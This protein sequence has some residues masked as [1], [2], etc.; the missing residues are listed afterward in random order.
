M[1]IID[2]RSKCSGCKACANAC[3]VQAITFTYDDE[4][5]WYPEVD[6]DK[7]VNCG[8][9]EKVCP[10][11]DD[12]HGVPEDN[13]CFETQFF[14]ARL[15][16]DSLLDGV[17][18]GGAFYGLA[19]AVLT[20]GGV[21]YGAAREDVDHVFHTRIS[22]A[23]D[24][25]K[26][27]KSKYLQSDMGTCYKTAREDLSAGRKVLFSGTGCQIAA[28]NRFLGKQHDN[29][30][31]CEV[32]CHGVPLQSVW[33]L[34]R[35]DKESR[36]GKKIVDIDFRDKSKGWSNNQYKTVYEDGSEE[37]ELSVSHPFHAGYLKGLFYRPSCGTCPFASM[38]R[39]AD[40]T[41]ADYW[42]Y[43]GR[44]KEGNLGVSL[45]GVNSLKGLNIMKSLEKWLIMEDSSGQD[46]LLSCRHMDDHP[47][48]NPLR[49]AFLKRLFKKGYYAAAK[50][51]IIDVSIINRIKN[52]IRRMVR[53]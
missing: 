11:R 50:E 2:D 6:K 5:T 14:A 48:E 9:C 44:L 41:L 52:R 47:V 22:S 19:M 7:C 53:R 49:S 37:Y 24:L 1:I 10:F 34:Y 3:P 16:D 39:V 25:V 40:I 27:R 30:Y 32:I 38:P 20:D 33:S 17:S 28:L 8:L 23:E 35:S 42:R 36:V 12:H 45:V 43:E 51:F 15:K 21:V 46:A 29:L 4:G 31:T 26:I 18:S 13:E